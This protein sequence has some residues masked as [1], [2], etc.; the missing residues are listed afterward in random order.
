MSR[1]FEKHGFHVTPV[2]ILS[3]LPTDKRQSE[4][5]YNTNHVLLFLNHFIIDQGCVCVCV[6][7]CVSQSMHFMYRSNY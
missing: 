1:S 3:D 7:V 6:C 5:V 4:K 2:H